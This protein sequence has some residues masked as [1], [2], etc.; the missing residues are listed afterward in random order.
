MANP[1]TE[2]KRMEFSEEA[3]EEQNL[4]EV[5]AAVSENKDVILKG[6]DLLATLEESGAL[7]AVNALVKHRKDALEN[8]VGEINKPQY[9]STLENMSE[10]FFLLGDLKVDQISYFV[11]KINEGM[12]EARVASKEEPTSYMGLMKTLK[13]PEVN[14]SITMLLG[15]LR[16]MGRE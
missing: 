7:D 6:I 15:F 2:M 3:I 8:V 13:N 4:A 9:A 5:T 16:G 11:E 14:R 12:G 10:L 1:I